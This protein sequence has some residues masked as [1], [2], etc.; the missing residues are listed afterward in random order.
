MNFFFNVSFNNLDESESNDRFNEITSDVKCSHKNEQEIFNIYNFMKWLGNSDP[1]TKRLNRILEMRNTIFNNNKFL[2]FGFYSQQ[3]NR[4]LAHYNVNLDDLISEFHFKLFDLIEK[5]NPNRKLKFATLVYTAL[6]RRMIQYIMKEVKH[7][8][9]R[10]MNFT[11]VRDQIMKKHRVKEDSGHTRINIGGA[12]SVNLDKNIQ[13]YELSAKLIAMNARSR[14]I[15]EDRFGF[16]GEEKT[17]EEISKSLN[18]SKERV[19][20]IECAALNGLRQYFNP[21]EPCLNG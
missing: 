16:N 6:N 18:I 4:M 13:E 21:S 20:Q 9:A 12:T 14:G 1:T 7:Y 17:L 2:V 5:F 8:N 19:R 15:I 11:D 3:K 10:F